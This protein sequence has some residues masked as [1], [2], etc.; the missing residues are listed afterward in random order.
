[1]AVAANADYT[2]FPADWLFHFR[3]GAA[4]SPW[5]HPQGRRLESI[6]EPRGKT[7]LL[8]PAHS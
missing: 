6:H 1:V 3:C 4:A 5:G 2:R 7:W 8:P